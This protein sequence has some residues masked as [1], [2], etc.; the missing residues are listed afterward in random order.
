ME[1]GEDRGTFYA[2][3]VGPGDPSLLTLQAIETLNS[4]SVIA[5]PQTRDGNMVALDI[6]RP[7][8]DLD[9]REIIPLGFSMSKDPAVREKERTE[10]AAQV[11]GRLERGLNVAMVNLGDVS[12]YSTAG[13]LLAPVRQAGYNVR[14]V[15]GVASYSA[16]ASA[17]GQILAEGDIPLHIIPVEGSSWTEALDLPGTKVFMKPG[18]RLP[19]LI[20]HLKETGRMKNAYLVSNCGMKGEMILS[21]LNRIPDKINY[22]TIVIVKE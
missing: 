18:S 8:I 22:F 13:Y 5:A 4:C 11:I 21:P 3:S 15:P 6:I 19:D 16:A 10:T 2:V 7:V 17:L 20:S 1:H 9:G 14:C 12:L